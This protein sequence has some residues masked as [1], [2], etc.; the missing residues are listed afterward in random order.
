MALALILLKFE[1]IPHAKFSRATRESANSKFN[2]FWIREPVNIGSHGM[3]AKCNLSVGEW[4][5]MW[6]RNWSARDRSSKLR[7]FS[8][9]P[10]SNFGA[11]FP[12][13]RPWSYVF[14]LHIHRL[15]SHFFSSDFRSDCT[16]RWNSLGT[17]DRIHAWFPSLVSRNR[18]LLF[19]SLTKIKI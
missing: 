7:A 17:P 1:K 9:I 16:I 2:G 11:F 12:S 19:R 14:T 3:I 5:D 4:S 18:I 13:G 15:S 10:A 6:L 8:R